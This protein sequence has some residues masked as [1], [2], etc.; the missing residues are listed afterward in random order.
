MNVS[1]LIAFVKQ[2]SFICFFYS[3]FAN[4]EVKEFKEVKAICF[5]A[6]YTTQKA[7][8]YNFQRPKGVITSLTTITSVYA[9]LLFLAS[10]KKTFSFI[11]CVN[12]V[13]LLYLL[14]ETPVPAG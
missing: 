4:K 3:T 11:V 5:I 9:K 8:V 14:S 12:K 6:K 7:I 2:R 1:A 10:F 13:V